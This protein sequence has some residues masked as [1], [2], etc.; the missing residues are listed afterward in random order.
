M[1][2]GIFLKGI[3]GKLHVKPY[4]FVAK[5]SKM[6][7]LLKSSPPLTG[8]YFLEYNFIQYRLFTSDRKHFH[9]L[10]DFIKIIFIQAVKTL[11]NNL[12]IIRI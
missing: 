9:K 11:E 1:E 5:M 8:Y 10:F 4:F 12:V 7:L 6:S 2:G 3:E